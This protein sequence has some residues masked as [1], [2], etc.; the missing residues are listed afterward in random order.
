MAA[1]TN[2]VCETATGRNEGECIY[3]QQFIAIMNKYNEDDIQTA[4]SMDK[5]D[6]LSITNAYLHLLHNHDT[7]HLFDAIYTLLD[8]CK[9]NMCSKFIR[10]DRNRMNID[11]LKYNQQM[12]I[13]IYACSSGVGTNT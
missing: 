4:E 3:L 12:N 6:L 7:D 8:D 1:S 5:M 2:S 9:L 13:N 10:S 11:A